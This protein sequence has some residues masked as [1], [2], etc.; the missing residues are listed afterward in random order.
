MAMRMFLGCLVIA[1][2]IGIFTSFFSAFIFLKTGDSATVSRIQMPTATRMKLSRKGTRQPQDRKAASPILETA[3][4]TMV[5]SS[6]PTKA[7]SWGQEP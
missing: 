1:S 5:D 6:R 7:P 3:R 4:N 2:T